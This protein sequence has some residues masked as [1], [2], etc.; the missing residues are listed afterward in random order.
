MSKLFHVIVTLEENGY[1]VTISENLN[2][3]ARCI[4][5]RV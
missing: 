1:T 4:E 2:V 5:V 3:A